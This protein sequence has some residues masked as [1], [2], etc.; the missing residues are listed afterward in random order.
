MIPVHRR[1][2]RIIALVLA[3]LVGLG[4]RAHAD[5]SPPA[6]PPRGVVAEDLPPPGPPAMPVAS[7][8]VPAAAFGAFALG[9]GVLAVGVGR[10]KGGAA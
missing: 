10:R 9:L 1:A 8:A 4:E 2:A 5:M 7:W 6:P 3:V